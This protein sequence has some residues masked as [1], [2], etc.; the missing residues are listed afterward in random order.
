MKY[1]GAGEGE[2]TF[3][4]PNLIRVKSDLFTTETL[5]IINKINEFSLKTNFRLF[6]IS[7]VKNKWN[8]LYSKIEFILSVD[9]NN[10]GPVHSH[11]IKDH[12]FDIFNSNGLD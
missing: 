11:Q 1:E 2:T 3:E 10:S 9:I 7:K 6:T 12:K 8:D 5:R 4:E